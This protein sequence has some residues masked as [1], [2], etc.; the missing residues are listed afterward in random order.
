MST[1]S[2]ASAVSVMSA[3]SAVTVVTPGQKV[4]LLE[5]SVAADDLLRAAAELGVEAFVATH[6][7]V[8]AD[9]RPELKEQMTGVV[10]TDFGDADRALDD[11]TAFCRTTGIDGVVACWEFLSPWPPC[12]R[13]GSDCPATTP[14]GR[15]PAATSA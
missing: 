5:A 8:H 3:V 9:Y 6:E 15:R 7:D 14:S 4:L 1:A 11:L 13:P 2:A 10:F 12:W